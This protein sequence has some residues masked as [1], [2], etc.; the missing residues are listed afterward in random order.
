MNKIIKNKEKIKIK[1]EQV[2]LSNEIV[3]TKWI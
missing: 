3:K 1:A 2:K